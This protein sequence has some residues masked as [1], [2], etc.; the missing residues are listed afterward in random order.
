MPCRMSC[1]P[2]PNPAISSNDYGSSNVT[3]GAATPMYYHAESLA[4]WPFA[5]IKIQ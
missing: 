5:S 2:T 1:G 4:T 3:S